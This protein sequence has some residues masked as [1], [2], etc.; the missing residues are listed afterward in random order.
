MT[1][2]SDAFDAWRQKWVGRNPNVFA[3]AMQAY[4]VTVGQG[5]LSADG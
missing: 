1:I 2:N 4:R 3:V 5:R